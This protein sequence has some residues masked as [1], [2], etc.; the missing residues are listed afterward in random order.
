M[1]NDDEEESYADPLSEILNPSLNEKPPKKS[2]KPSKIE[3]REI[4]ERAGPA[5]ALRLAS[6]TEHGDDKEAVPAAQAILDRIGFGKS[7]SS[8]PHSSTSILPARALVAALL[9]IGK[10]LGVQEAQNLQ[11]GVLIERK[12]L[13]AVS[14]DVSANLPADVRG[15]LTTS[16]HPQRLVRRAGGPG[17]R[18][19]SAKKAKKR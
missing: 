8:L 7:D 16:V 12:A 11:E 3:T 2:E 13:S 17:V 15:L 1:S 9:G 6:I 5:A 4:L 18:E 19:K 14:A 10:V